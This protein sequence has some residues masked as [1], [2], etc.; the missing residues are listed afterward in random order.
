MSI[1]FKS[2]YSCTFKAESFALQAIYYIFHIYIEFWQ[3]RERQK[4]NLC[5]RLPCASFFLKKAAL[6]TARCPNKVV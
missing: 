2:I 3:D 5:F 4:R 1:T 6:Q